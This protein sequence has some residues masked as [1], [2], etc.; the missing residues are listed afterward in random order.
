MTDFQTRAR[1][2][3]LS[4]EVFG[5][6][7]RWQKLV[8]QGYSEL[9][10][11]EVKEV[12]PADENGENGS[13]SVAQVP[14]LTKFGAKQFVVKHHTVES[15]EAQMLDLKA[16]REEFYARLAAMQAEQKAAEQA[17]A[18]N[19]ALSRE[20]HAKAAGSAQ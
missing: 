15:V 10:T 12:I 20:V 6:S 2:N 17:T 8:N 7:S 16:K 5:A 13:E 4:K 14:V 19:E 9:L 1:L 11:R 18:A 3:A